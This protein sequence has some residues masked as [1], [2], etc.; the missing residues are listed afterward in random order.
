[1]FR[2]VRSTIPPFLGLAVVATILGS[3]ATIQV[4]RRQA[5]AALTRLQEGFGR[6]PLY[7]IENRGQMDVPVRYYAHGR[8]TSLFFTSQGLTI[9][10]GKGD[11]RSE[12]A[13]GIEPLDSFNPFL[14][15][16]LR[17][18]RWD[19]TQEFVGA[20]PGVSPTAEGRTDAIVSYF[21]GPRK[22][23]KAG[24]PTYASVLYR[25]LWEGIDLIYEG[26]GGHLKYSFVV[27]PG[28]DPNNIRLTYRDATS[29]RLTPQGQLEVA[30]SGG[31]FREDV[32]YAY[33]VANGRR[34]KI[35]ARYAVDSATGSRGPREYGFQVG[36]FDHTKPLVVDPVM[37]VYAGYIGGSGLDDVGRGIA[38]DGAGNAYITGSASSDETTFPDGDGFG[39]VP[40]PD[41]THNGSSADAFVAK[42]N[43]SGTALVYAGYIGGSGGDAGRDIAVD[44]MGNAYVTGFTDSTGAGF[45][46]GDGFGTLAGPDLTYNGGFFDGFVAKVNAAGTALDYAGYIGG[47]DTDDGSGIQIDDAGNAYVTGKTASAHTSFPDGDG[48]GALGGPD[49]T[50]NGLQD[51]YVAKVNP[52]GTGLIY[53]G[54]IGGS[55]DDGGSSLDVDAGGNVYLSGSAASTQT[56]FPDG[57]G[58]GSLEGP[59]LTYNGGF[60]DAFVAK[61]NAS[62]TTLAYAG[63]VGGSGSDGASVSVDGAGNAYLAGAT[64]STETTF[65]DGDG[66]GTLGGPDLTYNGG[67]SDAFVAKVNATG[68]ALTYAGYVGGSAYDS[69]L[70]IALDGR[71]SAYLT[72]WTS[73]TE[74]TFPDGDGFGSLGAPDPSYNGGFFDAFVAAVNEEGTALR[75]AGFIGGDAEDL[76]ADIAVGDDG[77][78][79]VT[80]HTESTETTFPDGD[81]FG[82]LAGI[83]QTHNGGDFDVFVAKLADVPPPSP[84]V[85]VCAGMIATVIGTSAGE[86]LTGTSGPDV[87]V[88]LGGDD[89]IDGGA[90]DDR[91]CAGDGNDAVTGG[92]GNDTLDGEAGTDRVIESGDVNFTLTQ[93]SLTGLGT[94]T[95]TGIEAGT[96]IGG[97]GETLIDASAF[98]GPV[99]IAGGEGED[100]LI[101]GPSNDAIDGGGGHLDAVFAVGDVDFTL[102]D[103]SL[104]GLGTDALTGIEVVF[105]SGGPAARVIDASSFTG[106][107]SVLA[108]G[109]NDRVTGGSGRDILF[110]EGGKDRVAGRGGRDFLIG[111]GQADRLLGG[112]GADSLGGRRGNDRLFGGSGKDR[113]DGGR[114]RDVCLGGPG[115]DTVRFCEG[116]A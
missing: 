17:G 11:P 42:V 76:G 57:D 33:Q 44:A 39:P 100:V 29:V 23:W 98:T 28:A 62:G 53:A 88:G 3:V 94:D 24:L 77:S 65:P 49:V 93:A 7:F 54:Y 51:A 105:I 115:K 35:P 45:P 56:T 4:E 19:V 47:S 75:W 74:T 2:S 25:D 20:N 38:V 12:R 104:T 40:G 15:A 58:F 9:V 59:D 103:T 79:S 34:V 80:G 61:V 112:A 43:P 72:G 52:T 46:D 99:V 22:E 101:G 48:F 60:S 31:R 102:S 87:I 1:L 41:Q 85:Q 84:S 37:L 36:I 21:K 97:P 8:N 30:A 89:Q 95:L 111:G 116:G 110:G 63:Y 69:G 13:P 16:D 70:G 78:V 55:G 68:T 96:L 32:P 109:G 14:G 10:S 108:G 81:G 114:G 73:S 106:S 71:G 92:V 26:R 5:T 18:E 86:T 66:F 64:A 91:I 27:E 113:L 83:D 6:L 67:L 90:G 82:S 50:H 107:L